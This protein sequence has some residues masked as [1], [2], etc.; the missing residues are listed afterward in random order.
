[1]IE[2]FHCRV[3]FLIFRLRY[4]RVLIDAF[5]DC[6]SQINDFH[7]SDGNSGENYP[8]CVSSNFHTAVS[9]ETVLHSLLILVA[10]WG[11]RINEKKMNLRLL[12]ATLRNPGSDE[13]RKLRCSR[14]DGYSAHTSVL[15]QEGPFVR[16]VMLS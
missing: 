4:R 7:L 13:I 3:P 1:M 5:L 12:R 2:I 15:L 10:K 9:R 16:L 14:T 6:D 11:Y 8:S